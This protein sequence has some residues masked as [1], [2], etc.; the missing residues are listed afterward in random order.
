MSPGPTVCTGQG[1]EGHKV[2]REVS[3]RRG[4]RVVH[5]HEGGRWTENEGVSP[6]VGDRFYKAS[7]VGTPTPVVEAD[8]SGVG[9]REFQG[10]DRLRWTVH[11]KGGRRQKRSEWRDQVRGSKEDLMSLSEVD[12]DYEKTIGDK[13]LTSDIMKVLIF[14]FGPSVNHSYI[15]H[16]TYGNR[17]LPGSVPEV[18]R[19]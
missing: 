9:R 1:S 15:K 17:L 18:G 11:S 14:V 2:G 19:P 8:D 3:G 13:R 6:G 5:G 4:L 10:P 12:P 7:G 16:I